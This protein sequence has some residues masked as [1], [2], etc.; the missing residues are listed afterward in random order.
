MKNS[1]IILYTSLEGQVKVDV[2]FQDETVW[3]TQKRMADLFGV[4]VNTV[5]YHVKEIYKSG[6]LTEKATIRKFRIV[7]KEGAREVERETDFYNL[8]MIIAVGYR[9]NSRQA[10]QFRI[11]ATKVLKEYMIK[12]FALDDNRL[13]NGII[14]GKSYFD[15]LLERI[16]DIR[17]SERVFYQKITDIY[18][19]CSVD[20]DPDSGIT[21][22]FYATVQNKLHW[23][24]HHHTAAELIVERADAAKP[25]MGLSTWKNAP[26]GKIRKTDV[27]VAKNYLN[28]GELKKLNRIVSMYLDYAEEQAEKKRPMTMTDWVAKL[29][30]FLQ[31]NEKEVLNNPGKVSAELAKKLAE[32]EFGK[33]EEAQ[34]AIEASQ[35]VS[36]FDK[37]V[38]KSKLIEKKEPKRKDND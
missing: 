2:F 24:I 31:F 12:G 15:E 20:Y 14:P 29:D 8:D 5:N 33:F 1:E 13:K 28:E 23:A 11:W 10:T 6:E 35:P 32:T 19:Q 37:L 18:A 17:S 36:D 7:Q 3:L 26:E 9:V 22:K 34:K 4:E 27:T 16:R 21:H 38:E 25:H 30:A